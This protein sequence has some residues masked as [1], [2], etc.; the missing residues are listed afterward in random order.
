[1]AVK[2]AFH[3]V[4][5]HS[6]ATEVSM[7]MTFANGELEISIQDNG[8]GFDPASKTDGN[9]LVNMKQRLA[10]IGGQCVIESQ[11]GKGTIVR[12]QLVVPV[13]EKIS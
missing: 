6:H 9:G 2:E 4:I 10:N 11:A 5:K 1:M 7:R 3:N 12:F 8:A 13:L